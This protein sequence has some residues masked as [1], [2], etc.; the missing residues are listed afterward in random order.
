M[1][2]PHVCFFSLA[3]WK[4]FLLLTKN[5]LKRH[6][7]SRHVVSSPM[8]VVWWHGSIKCMTQCAAQ[9]LEDGVFPLDGYV[10]S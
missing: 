3:L 10:V 9:D 8:A 7:D 5:I 2:S 1:N 6:G 4:F